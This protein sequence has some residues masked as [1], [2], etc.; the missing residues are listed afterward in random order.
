MGVDCLRSHLSQS[1]K[2]QDHQH[3]RPNHNASL[4]FDGIN[5]ERPEE[6]AALR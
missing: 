4:D 6:F 2:Q 5:A 1:H 3:L